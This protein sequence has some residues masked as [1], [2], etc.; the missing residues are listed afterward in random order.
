MT[1]LKKRIR[2]IVSTRFDKSTEDYVNAILR[3]FSEYVEKMPEH[4]CEECGFGYI[5]K[6]A[7]LKSLKE[8]IQG[9]K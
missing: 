5:N 1:T 7:I 6:M 4:I 9:E 8:K 3:A 2:E